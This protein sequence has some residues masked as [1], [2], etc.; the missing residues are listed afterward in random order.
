[1]Y[2]KTTSSELKLDINI[3]L[4]STK[5][6]EI[7]DLLLKTIKNT[8]IIRTQDTARWIAYLIRNKYGRDRTWQWVRENWDWINATFGGDKSYDDYPQYVAMALVSQKQLSEYTDFFGPKRSDPALTRVIDM[9]INEIT[10]RVNLIE[11]NTDDVQK[12][13]L[14]L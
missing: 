10:N 2:E 4:T 14:N 5:K 11:K 7:I 9:G 13:L 1:M 3:G 8:S 12:C 6:K